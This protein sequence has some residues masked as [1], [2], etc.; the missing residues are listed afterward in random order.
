[1][2]GKSLQD[3]REWLDS[4]CITLFVV[5]STKN[6]MAANRTMQLPAEPG[7]DVESA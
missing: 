4:L 6:K 7:I 3:T 5:S 1:M 2:S